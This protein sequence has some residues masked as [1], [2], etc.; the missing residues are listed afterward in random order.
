MYV[1]P[2]DP[3]ALADALVR[4]AG[5]AALRARLAEAGRL[6]ARRFDIQHAASDLRSLRRELLATDPLLVPERGGQYPQFADPPM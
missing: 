1:E 4:L 5:D 2:D 6:R 3:P